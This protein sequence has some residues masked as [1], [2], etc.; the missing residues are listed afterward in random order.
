MGARVGA[1]IRGAG[2]GD[3]CHCCKDVTGVSVTAS[4]K[5]RKLLDVSEV[6]ESVLFSSCAMLL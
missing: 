5:I 4:S 2:G 1:E 3:Y 6:V